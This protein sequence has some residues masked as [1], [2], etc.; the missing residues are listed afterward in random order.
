M[1]RPYSIEAD[2]TSKI[3]EADVALLTDDADGDV[4]DSAKVD[5]A[6]ERADDMVDS[7]IRGRF[8]VPLDPTPPL[9]KRISTNLAIF[10]LYERKL[11]LI[12]PEN[13]QRLR[14][15]AVGDLVKIQ[16]GKIAIE[17]SKGQAPASFAARSTHGEKC[18]TKEVLDQF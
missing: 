15:N 8:E 4:I 18:F 5:E 3:P 7:Y 9:I 16:E 10:E 2:V 11:N 6:I 13:I 17:I 1:G 14:D 12:V